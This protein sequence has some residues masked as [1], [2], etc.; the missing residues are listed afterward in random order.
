MIEDLN[1]FK[2]TIKNYGKN[3]LVSLLFAVFL[4]VTINLIFFKPIP[5]LAAATPSVALGLPLEVMIGENFSFS[6]TFSNTGSSTGYGPYIDLVSPVTGTDGA[7]A[8][9]YYGINFTSATYLG[10][11][12][13]ASQ[14]TFPVSGTGCTAGQTQVTHPYAVNTM[15]AKQVVCGIPGDKLV[16]SQLPVGS[17]VSSQPDLN[18]TVNVT[19]SNFADVGV[20]LTI[21]S[22][23]GFRYGNDSLYNPATDPTIFGTF[24]SNSTTPTILRL[25]KT[26]IGPESE[27]A[28]GPNFF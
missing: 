18:V 24:S 8:A 19:L 6:T 28:T 17:F 11:S 16:V 20:P 7:G 15:N 26:Y 27:T 9:L 13:V 5:V 4:L 10:T 21:L 2:E 25:N 14:L 22:S 1:T 3:G 23:A 12:V